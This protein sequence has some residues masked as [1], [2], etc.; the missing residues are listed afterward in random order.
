MLFAE[1]ILAASVLG[2]VPWALDLL[3][4]SALALL[5]LSF[6]DVADLTGGQGKRKRV[7]DNED[8]DEAARIRKKRKKHHHVPNKPLNT[9]IQKCV[10]TC[11][12]TAVQVFGRDKYE[13]DEYLPRQNEV[14]RAEWTPRS[15]IP[16]CVR[17]RTR[18]Q[19]RV[20][21]H[22][23]NKLP[24]IAR[25]RVRV[26]LGNRLVETLQSAEFSLRG[27]CSIVLRTRYNV[28]DTINR[29]FVVLSIV[30]LCTQESTV[31]LT[32]A[33]CKFQV[34]TIFGPPIRDNVRVSELLPYGTLAPKE[35]PDRTKIERIQR[36]FTA[37]HLD[38]VCY[39]WAKGTS[40][41][42]PTGDGSIVFQLV[43]NSRAVLPYPKQSRKNRDGW[44]AL[45]AHSPS[46]DCTQMASFF[47]DALGTLGVKA[48]DFELKRTASV[49]T[50]EG[51]QS[52]ICTFKVN[53]RGYEDNYPCHGVL[54]IEYPT[55][56]MWCYDTTFYLPEIALKLNDALIFGE[57]APFILKWVEWLWINAKGE[58]K[59]I[60]TDSETQV[61]TA[62]P[63]TAWKGKM[64][65]AAKVALSKR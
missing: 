41:L 16:C 39:K 44:N 17:I 34:Y 64:I 57:K 56:E 5:V 45:D 1:V 59:A 47:A 36:F 21:L 53:R 6:S 60:T 31:N 63:K 2:A 37:N 30:E 23:T 61:E 18:L 48:V 27:Y 24:Q 19:F 49:D 11:A 22:S 33:T 9:I 50:V 40:L 14:Y 15:R 28:H 4:A 58:Y 32:A 35:Q 46:A 20:F 65:T 13:L 10:P 3:F 8:S 43:R 12:V 42:V 55:N 25:L 62:N 38:W 29:T 26:R 54:L 51:S 52:L 7:E